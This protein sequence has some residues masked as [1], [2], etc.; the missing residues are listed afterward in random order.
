MLEEKLVQHEA[1]GALVAI[2]AAA[3]A[4]LG[5]GDAVARALAESQK[6]QMQVD[7]QWLGMAAGGHSTHMQ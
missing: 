5:A 2:E 1:G 3:R 7:A 4:A 6:L